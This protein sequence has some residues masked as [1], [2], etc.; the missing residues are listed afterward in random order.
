MITLTLGRDK[1]AYM[2]PA[3][4]VARDVTRPDDACKRDCL[5]DIA[6]LVTTLASGGVVQDSAQFRERCRQLVEQFEVMLTRRDYPE[7]VKREA[8]IALC[9]LLDEMALRNLP[10]EARHAWEVR[11]LQVER[12][13]IYDAGRRIIDR[14][15]THLH[16]P[17]PDVDLLE[18]YAAIM[19]M[20]F[21]GRYAVEGKA[22]RAALIAALNARLE[23]IRP[24]GEAPF[25]ADPDGSRLSG[26]IHRLLP[27][28]LVALTCLAAVAMWIAGSELLDTQVMHI[29]SARVV[30]P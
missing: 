12:F 25:I 13:S 17:S 18:F 16:E 7:D 30:G 5:H 11:P 26:G 9:G 1:G 3:R 20:G 4:G 19:G 29:G 10:E 8:L 23:S 14:I 22:K 24:S 28:I 2:K 6:L 15:E 21:V 27:W